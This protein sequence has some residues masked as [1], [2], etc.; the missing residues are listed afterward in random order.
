MSLS[1]RPQSFDDCG[2]YP[3][4]FSSDR[5][6]SA[7]LRSLIIFKGEAKSAVVLYSP[8]IRYTVIK[9]TFINTR[10]HDRMHLYHSLLLLSLAVLL[11]STLILKL[12]QTGRETPATQCLVN[13]YRSEDRVRGRG[14]VIFLYNSNSIFLLV[15]LSCTTSVSSGS[16]FLQKKDMEDG[17][18]D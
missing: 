17:G 4:S 13:F 12:Q 5:K 9:H 15:S 18:E 16:K 1:G 2:K 14:A 6:T 10:Q 11:R 3:I 7:K 8:R